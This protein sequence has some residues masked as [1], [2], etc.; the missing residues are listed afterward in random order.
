MAF[1]V[2]PL[3]A[4]LDFQTEAVRSVVIVRI[5]NLIA[6]RSRGL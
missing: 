5:L 3:N 2:A 6:R 1:G 4:R